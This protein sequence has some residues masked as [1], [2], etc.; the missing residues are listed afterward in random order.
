M[1]AA[2]LTTDE[3]PSINA[4]A[5]A[6]TIEAGEKQNTET[7]R[8][9]A[10]QQSLTGD[11][12][13]VFR[14]PTQQRSQAKYFIR[15]A[16][17]YLGVFC[18]LTT[19][20]IVYSI[21]L[22]A[23]IH[24]DG[25]THAMAG[26]TIA[27]GVFLIVRLLFSITT[28][29]IYPPAPLIIVPVLLDSAML[30]TFIVISVLDYVQIGNTGEY[31][32]HRDYDSACDVGY[33]FAFVW[34]TMFWLLGTPVIGYFIVQSKMLQHTR[35]FCVNLY[36]QVEDFASQKFVFDDEATVNA[37]SAQLTPTNRS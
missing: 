36:K 10:P 24:C 23:A 27:F 13:F 3:K 16:F 4:A 9:T 35:D 26:A 8:F 12:G 29:S 7:P 6:L 5:T 30:V 11:E 1:T 31:V 2:T 21:V 25:V 20:M 34:T 18:I 33:W 22:K 14:L 37:P 19:F 32:H 15:V 28:K 17:I